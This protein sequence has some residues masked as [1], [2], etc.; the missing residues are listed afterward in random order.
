MPEPTDPLNSWKLL[1]SV[2]LTAT[3][4]DAQFLL[5]RERQARRRLSVMLRIHSRLNKIR[6]DRERAELRHEAIDYH[7]S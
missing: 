6:A 7:A 2:L 3:E 1:N 4:E 5:H